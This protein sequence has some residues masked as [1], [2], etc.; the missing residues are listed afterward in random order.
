MLLIDVIQCLDHQMGPLHFPD[1]PEAREISQKLQQ[2]SGVDKTRVYR[3]KYINV[4]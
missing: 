3:Y 2:A 4:L 1:K